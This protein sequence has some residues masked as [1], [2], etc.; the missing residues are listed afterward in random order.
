MPVSFSKGFISIY[1]FHFFFSTTDCV[2]LGPPS[3]THQHL[4]LICIIN[5]F[6]GYTQILASSHLNLDCL[7]SVALPDFKL[8]DPGDLMSFNFLNVA[9]TFSSVRVSPPYHHHPSNSTSRSPPCIIVVLFWFKSEH[10]CLIQRETMFWSRL[11]SLSQFFK[12]YQ[13][14]IKSFLAQFSAL[15]FSNHFESS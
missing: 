9:V 14:R 5:Y 7:F 15:N 3:T 12:P 4:S 8:S 11:I 1:I 10:K 2:N 6:C 13:F